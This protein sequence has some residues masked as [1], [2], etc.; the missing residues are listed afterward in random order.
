MITTSQWCCVIEQ[1]SMPKKNV[2][3][4]VAAYFSRFKL[5]MYAQFIKLILTVQEDS[6]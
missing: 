3:V 1:N 6:V 2:D 5:L 4:S